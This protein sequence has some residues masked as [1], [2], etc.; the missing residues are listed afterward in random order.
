M[1]RFFSSHEQHVYSTSR[2]H[3]RL[4]DSRTSGRLGE[5]VDGIRNVLQSSVDDKALSPEIIESQKSTANVFGSELFSRLYGEPSRLDEVSG[6]E[7]EASAHDHM[8]DMP[9]W[10]EMKSMVDGD[11]DFAALA[12][13][14]MMDK[15]KDH[16]GK[17]LERKEQEESDG[18]SGPQ[19]NDPTKFKVSAEDG[20]RIALRSAMSEVN[21]EVRETK[22]AL[23]GLAPGLGSV[24]PTH[25]QENGV[26]MEIAEMLRGKEQ[27]QEIIRRA[28]RIERIAAKS[29]PT[30]SDFLREE[31]VGV[32]TGNDI[33]HLMPSELMKL[34]DE[35]LEWLLLKDIAC[36]SA[37]QYDLQGKE[38]QGRGPIVLLLDESGSMDGEP[39]M[40]ARATA[41]A[42]VSQ[43][44]KENRDVVVVGF[45][46]QVRSVHK[47][48]PDSDRGT[49]AETVSQL[50]R[51]NV[52][53]G[54]CF[55]TVLK[56]ALESG[57][58]SEKADLIFV[59]DD[60][61]DVSPEILKTLNETREDKGLQVFG[62][63]VGYGSLSNAVES[64]CDHTWHLNSDE[65]HARGI[66]RRLAR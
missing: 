56:Y 43:A 9:E 34:M 16:L 54:T 57:V 55:N 13:A 32:S 19:G 7:W 26:R 39:H 21:D 5:A 25:E 23:A 30:P 51:T 6:A 61:C 60:Q 1:S 49:V 62:I 14:G 36:S 28:G 10:A 4:Y 31:I 27:L 12:A 41:V 33:A 47:L 64:F 24:P 22:A 63:T 37:Q 3:R 2:W 38:P 52:G 53:G 44:Q 59:T 11:P 48:T 35:D 66:G 20:L 15:L 65:D 45:D 58:R 17:Y 42:C 50:L 40:W 18:E 46:T 29:R 8:A